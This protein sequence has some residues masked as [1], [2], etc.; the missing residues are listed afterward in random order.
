M[1]VMGASAFR[2]QHLNDRSDRNLYKFGTPADAASI[3]NSTV[4][5]HA[6]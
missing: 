6:G 1:G 5:S 3:F 2:A 4:V